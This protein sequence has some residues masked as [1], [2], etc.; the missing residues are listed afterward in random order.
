MVQFKSD[1]GIWNVEN[2]IGNQFENGFLFGIWF[3]W[4]KNSEK[5]QYKK[6]LTLG[7]RIHKSDWEPVLQCSFSTVPFSDP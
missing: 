6:L 3:I 5:I 2:I 1:S 4:E 7:S